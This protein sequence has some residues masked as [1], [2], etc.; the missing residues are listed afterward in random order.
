MKEFLKEAYEEQHSDYAFRL[1]LLQG[2]GTIGDAPGA[3]VE[4]AL[5]ATGLTNKYAA[6]SIHNAIDNAL[7]L[8]SATGGAKAGTKSATKQLGKKLKKLKGNAN[9]ELVSL[10]EYANSA[11]DKLRLRTVL[12]FKGILDAHGNLTPIAVE[13]AKPIRLKDEVIG[14]PSIVKV[15]TKDGSDILDWQKLKTEKIT[16]VEW[17]IKGN[18]FLQKYQ[19]R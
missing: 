18:P 4:A 2:M 12:A 13:K 11:S 7:L 6:R 8:T 16:Y 10:P 5:R 15:L 3:T 9:Q 14:N 19:D 17:P 1:Q